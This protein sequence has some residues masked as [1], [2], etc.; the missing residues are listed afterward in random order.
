MNVSSAPRFIVPLVGL[1][2]FVGSA[3]SVAQTDP[4]FSH[5]LR[6]WAWNTVLGTD[7]AN[8]P[9]IKKMIRVDIVAEGTPNNSAHA[10]AIEFVNAVT[11]QGR[12]NGGIALFINHFGHGNQFITSSSIPKTNPWPTN[13]ARFQNT[14]SA[15]AHVP[16]LYAHPNDVYAGPAVPD[17]ESAPY[18]GLP[19]PWM[20]HGI[21]ECK[22][23][24]YDFIDKCED[25]GLLTINRLHQ[26][27]EVEAGEL[28][29]NN[30]YN[31][32][33]RWIGYWQ[34]LKTDPRW[35]A[36]DPVTGDVMPDAVVPGFPA[37]TLAD[38]WADAYAAGVRD[39]PS[40]IPLLTEQGSDEFRS[41]FRWFISVKRQAEAAALE[42]SLYAPMRAAYGTKCSD[43]DQSVR[44]DGVTAGDDRSNVFMG[45]G[46]QDSHGLRAHWDGFGD[47]QAL[48]M[49]SYS[50]SYGIATS[51]TTQTGHENTPWWD[52]RQLAVTGDDGVVY[53]TDFS[54]SNP[55]WILDAAIR[56]NRYTLDACIRSN[57]G[58]NADKLMSYITMPG[59]R[60]HVNGPP[61]GLYPPNT[62]LR[63]WERSYYWVSND[64]IRRILMLSRSRGVQEYVVWSYNH[65]NTEYT[66]DRLRT[67]VDQVWGYTAT[68]IGS[69]SGS[70]SGSAGALNAAP[71][72]FVTVTAPGT[73]TTVT[74]QFANTYATTTAGLRLNLELTSSITDRVSA[75]A[76]AANGS[77]V[78]LD[79]DPRSANTHVGVLAGKRVHLSG[80]TGSS[81]AGFNTDPVVVRISVGDPNAE[82]YP[83]GSRTIGLD[84]VQIA[85]D[86]DVHRC[87]WDFDVD[88]WLTVNE[89]DIFMAAYSASCHDPIA[90][91]N[92]DGFIDFTDSD[93][94]TGA[95][96]TESPL[97]DLNYDGF[98]DFIDFDLFISSF[99]DPSASGCD[100]KSDLFADVNGDGLVDSRDLELFTTL[101]SSGECVVGLN[102]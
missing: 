80:I 83:T 92:R 33:F 5:G 71:D 35:N 2:T 31:P 50:S 93:L 3:A 91:L 69:S 85:A 87:L 27:Q 54:T 48:Q 10:K 1:V 14:S 46:F 102:E 76:Q 96:S 61:A 57:G 52:G 51:T 89:Y 72:S 28:F 77:W 18:L 49:Y 30:K 53:G 82:F 12:S 36:R 66:W 47:I 55:E 81:A 24:T 40:T 100:P 68:S 7:A 16:A 74:V 22:Q 4:V 75:E 65:A 39:D 13:A 58:A 60:D 19:T 42:E 34:R 44:L 17:E 67:M 38:L 26:D 25:L 78:A 99:D 6:F 45:G 43:Y 101:F 56:Q 41:W 23:W 37:K 84:L 90:D 11:S 29:A 59:E 98:V 73:P 70:V 62:F 8:D 32:A 63:D 9:R 97:A 21:A 79:L 86:D 95:F 64:A 88:G 20:R 15:N 94:F